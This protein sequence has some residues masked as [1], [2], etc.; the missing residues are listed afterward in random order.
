M[1]PVTWITGANGFIGSHLVRACTENKKVIK[2]FRPEFFS[3]NTNKDVLSYPLEKTGINDA[4]ANHGYPSRVY[5]LAGAP[6]VGQSFSCP[7][8]DFNSNVITTE[9][10]LNALSGSKAHI[11]FSSSA[12]VYGDGHS[13]GIRINDKLS[14]KSP[15]GHHKIISEK[16]IKLYTEHFDLSATILRLFSVYGNG[17]RKQLLYDCCSKL[18]IYSINTPLVLGG[19]GDELRDWLEVS[20]VVAAMKNLENLQSG[21]FQIYNLATGRPTRIE[22]IANKIISLWGKSHQ[23]EFNK[24]KRPGDPFSLTANPSSLPPAFVPK[25]TID[26][27]IEKY[28]NWFKSLDENMDQVL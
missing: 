24:I 12:A 18:N 13:N 28:I 27:G 22:Y 4:I 9:V 1:N 21:D 20:D 5:H 23:L 25:I 10:L 11:I 6:T 3:S 2:F 26:Q 15:Y 14:P 17:L 7:H 16:L 19:T 8:Q